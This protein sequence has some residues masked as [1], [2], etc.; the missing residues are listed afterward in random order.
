MGKSGFG[1][2][3]GRGI[4]AG[5]S[6]WL[7]AVDLGKG[8]SEPVSP[9]RQAPVWGAELNTPN[10]DNWNAVP[11]VN[12]SARSFDFSSLDIGHEAIVALFSQTD[13]P[14]GPQDLT[15]IWYN[16]YGEEIYT[17]STTFNVPAG[18]WGWLYCYSYIGYV[19]WEL[20][21]NEN[22]SVTFLLNGIILERINFTITGV[23]NPILTC[24]AQV[25]LGGTLHWSFTGF[26]VGASVN[27]NV[28]G[29]GGVTVI[30]DANGNGSG[31]FSLGEPTGSYTLQASSGYY[32]AT[33][34]FTVGAGWTVLTPITVTIGI[35]A[36]WVIL[37]PIMVTIGITADWVI[38]TPITT[39]LTAT[40]WQILTPIDTTIL[41][42]SWTI[43]TPIDTTLK[44]TSWEIL[45]PINTL[46]GVT[47]WT[48]LTPIEG[49]VK[50]GPGEGGGIPMWVWFVVGGVAVVTVLVIALKSSG[51]KTIRFVE[52]HPEILK[53]VAAAA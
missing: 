40:N 51:E 22:Y 32:Y 7:Y 23:H 12:G 35:T 48:V 4:A 9:W 42:T 30:A 29:G 26:P 20:Y 5:I 34:Q 19:P 14:E 3:E 31:D 10:A 6:A 47:N 16:Q 15:I 50:A 53:A 11:E 13:I 38:L 27:V 41:A 52:E 45:T 24:D 39:T 17:F 28:V 25:P 43:L 21:A 18:G 36:D 8:L 33:A 1:H 2:L 46:L 49:I 44:A 37:T